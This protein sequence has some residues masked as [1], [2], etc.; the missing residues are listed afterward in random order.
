MEVTSKDTE[1][2]G[3]QLADIIRLDRDDP[4]DETE[5][6]TADDFE[7]SPKVNIFL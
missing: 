5:N 3:R 4:V 2:P 6:E 1:T 7:V